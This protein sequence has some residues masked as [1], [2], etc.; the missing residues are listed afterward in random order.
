[1]KRGAQ[2]TGK[3]AESINKSFGSFEEFKNQFSKAGKI[4]FDN[5][6]AWLSLDGKCN[7]FICSTPYQD[8]PLMYIAEKKGISCLSWMYGNMHIN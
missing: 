2:P 1:V 4:R 3:F 6:W 8:N 5:G 7:L